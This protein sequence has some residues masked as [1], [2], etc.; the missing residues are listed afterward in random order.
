MLHWMNAVATG[1]L[2][3][4]ILARAHGGLAGPN[5]VGPPIMTSVALAFVCYW[6]V[7]LWPSSKRGDNNASGASGSQGRNGDR[8]RTRNRTTTKSGLAKQRAHLKDA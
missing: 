4:P 8:D 1:M 7:I 6:V 3:S 5:E 2:A